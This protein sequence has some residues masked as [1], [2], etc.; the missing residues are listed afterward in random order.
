[1][2]RSFACMTAGTPPAPAATDAASACKL[3]TG[4]GTAFAPMPVGTA[5]TQTQ[6]SGTPGAVAVAHLACP[7]ALMVQP[8]SATSSMSAWNARRRESGLL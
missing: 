3:V 2:Y 6:V 8:E 7:L 4:R 1:M 5:A